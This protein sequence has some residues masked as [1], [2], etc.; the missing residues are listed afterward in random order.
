VGSSTKE[1]VTNSNTPHILKEKMEQI[2]EFLLAWREEMRAE[3]EAD[4][5][6][7]RAKLEEISARTDRKASPEMITATDAKADVKL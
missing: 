6:K 5:E 2:M 3:R 4:R 7:W 1:L